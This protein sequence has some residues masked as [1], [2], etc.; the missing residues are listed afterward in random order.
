VTGEGRGGRFGDLAPRV[1]S[2]VAL[3]AVGLG[4]TW[5]GGWA[6]LALV[7]VV[8]ALMVW[9]L[10]RLF[11]PG[12]GWRPAGLA[13]IAGAAVAATAVLP[14]AVTLPMILLP[15]L[16]GIAVLPTNRRIFAIY[17]SFTVVAGFGLWHLRNDLGPQGFQA[18]LWL[19]FVVVATDVAGYFAGRLIG[20]PKFWPR[21][22]PSKTWS[23][24][25]AGWIGAAGVGIAFAAP[26]PGA[27]AALAGVSVA[28]SMASQIGDAA[29]SAIKRRVGVKDAS[30]LI[31]GHGGV[32]DRFDGMLGAAVMFLIA[33]RVVDL[34]PLLTGG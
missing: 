5:A 16:A 12:A 29:E 10:A 21:V 2:G 20:G 32:M 3:A 26:A 31:P 18:M 6:F 7:V 13:A 33:E 27:A 22:S 14:V 4:A 11:A 8:T 23:G 25:V 34:P 24:T 28:V 30:G 1:A 19:A 17:A 15:A 9:E